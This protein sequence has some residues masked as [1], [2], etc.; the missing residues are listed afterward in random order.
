MHRVT[1]SLDESLALAFDQLVSE[2][3]YQSRSEAVRDLV[4]QAV[5]GRRL[6]ASNEGHC[7]ASLSYVFDHRTRSLAQRLVELQHAHHHLVVATM[8]AHL[9]HNSCLETALLTGASREVRS[10][11]DAIQSERGVRFTKI[12]LISVTPND[13]HGHSHDSHR[14]SDGAHLSPHQG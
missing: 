10:F 5:D 2:Q 7:V 8:R 11:A 12:N 13:D 1:I 3:G 14:H 4:R 9:D 6:A